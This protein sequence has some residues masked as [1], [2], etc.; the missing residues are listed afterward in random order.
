MRSGQAPGRQR[1]ASPWPWRWRPTT[2]LAPIIG[3]GRR[4]FR[5]RLPAGECGAPLL[6]VI[7]TPRVL[8]VRAAEE[9]DVRA[10]A[11]RVRRY[12]EGPRNSDG[13]FD[14][15][16][17]YY[18]ATANGLALGRVGG[19]GSAGLGLERFVSGRQLQ[20]LL[21][22]QHPTT[23]APLLGATGAA[24][25]A[26]GAPK[27]SRSTAADGPDD[28]LLSLAEAS[29]L[30]GVS[31]AYLRR[32]AEQNA[33]AGSEPAPPADGAAQDRLAAV[34]DPSSGAWRVRRAEVKRYIADREPPATVI[35]YDFV[36][37]AP[38]SVSLLWAFGDER[39]R[40]QIGA[41]M[42]ASVDV[43]LG[44]LEE[45][46]ARGLVG[47]RMHRGE[48]LV[49]A[50]YLHDVARTI[51]P[52]LHVHNLVANIVRIPRSDVAG[53]PVVDDNGV[54][55]IDSRAVDGT[56]ML[57]HSL[58][59]GYLAGA[60]LRHQL[61]RRLGVEWALPHNGVAEIASFPPDLLREF[62]TARARLLAEHASWQLDNPTAA[63]LEAARRQ[64]RD[65]KPVLADSEIAA[66]QRR[67]LA[68]LGWTPEA[69][70]SLIAGR[71]RR[72]TEVSDDEIAELFEQLSGPS[73]VTEKQTTFTPQHVR[74]AIA[75][76]AGER[77]DADR[78]DA[79][80]EQ[81][82]ADERVLLVGSANRRA[83]R[84]EPEAVYTTAGLLAVEDE[85]LHL[86]S[87]G[88][89]A[90]TGRWLCP[91]ADDLVD[92]GVQAAETQL[93]EE[94]GDPTAALAGEQAVMMRT[95]VNSG[96]LLRCAIGPAG[97]GKTE[98]LRAGVAAWTSAGYAVIGT[99][100][101]GMQAERLGTTLGIASDNLAALLA[102]WD[103]AEDGQH[104]ATLQPG[105]VIVVDE[106]TQVDSRQ[107]TRLLRWATLT[108]STVIAIG[109]PAQLG[110][111][112]AGG[113]FDAVV[114]AAERVPRLE[115]I[116]RQAGPELAGVRA[117]LTDLRS[118][119][120][121][122]VQR[123]LQRLAAEGRA[124]VFHERTDLYDQV[125]ADWYADR[126][127]RRAAVDSGRRPPKV[128]RMM[129]PTVAQCA[130]LN[131]G[132]RQLLVDD[133]TVTGQ[134]IST[135]RHDFAVGD[136]V[137]T[138]TQRGHTLLAE[139]ADKSDY[140][141]TGTVGIVVAVHADHDHPEQQHVVVDFEGKGRVVV[142]WE[143]LTFEFSDGRR[144]GLTHGY[145]LTADRAQG[146][147]MDA[148]RGVA[149]DATR[150]DALYVMLSRGQRHIAAYL[151]RG[152]DLRRGAN[153]EEFLPELTDR[154]TTLEAV[155]D[156]ARRH[157]AEELAV[158]FDPLAV[159]ADHLARRYLLHDLTRRRLDLPDPAIPMAALHRAESAAA[160]RAGA[161]G[162][163]NPHPAVVETL[164]ARPSG[165]QHRAQW[166]IA[167]RAVAIYTARHR[168][169]LTGGTAD[170]AHAPSQL[171]GPRP[172]AEGDHRAAA[173]GLIEA[174]ADRLPADVASRFWR[175]RERAA[176]HSAV[177]GVHALLAHGVAPSDI[178]RSLATTPPDG[179]TAAAVLA[180]R[181]S[182]L[183]ADRGI[184]PGGYQDPPP[185]PHDEWDAA[186]LAVRRAQTARHYARP[187]PEV[188]AERHAT[189]DP[190]LADILTAAL[191]AHVDQAVH[192]A[193]NGD[194]PAYLTGLLGPRHDDTTRWDH[195]CREIETWRHYRLG[196]LFGHSAESDSDDP[197][198]AALGPRPAD[199]AGAYTWDRLASGQDRLDLGLDHAI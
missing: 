103:S 112:G 73:G 164:G 165:G 30:A 198:L 183:C 3:P 40:R 13:V 71:P 196:L 125:V 155:I 65:P 120:P 23:G 124:S 178:A 95:L 12:V 81:F 82:L 78:I 70:T 135:G 108:G 31:P 154:R 139:G 17:A 45:H 147:T 107:A 11:K 7:V 192:R 33:T 51:E 136:E 174:W 72:P 100:A 130:T 66:R 61:A 19:A 94:T 21:A 74:R 184:D 2:V 56:A 24:G 129:A 6:A 101:R 131:R 157:R 64:T 5:V 117:A 63:T 97:T 118:G 28:E 59:A 138:L 57:D 176:R 27:G 168:P 43:A 187:L 149:S 29:H 8:G 76:W 146:S 197:L 67:Q 193:A 114:N 16:V 89:V 167:A 126:A 98:A 58:T 83:A 150:R 119:T 173:V 54:P 141:R 137:V 133:G 179:S 151:I 10:A 49:V 62:S 77:L 99:A 156:R 189:S 85:L 191:D 32:L 4:Q 48:G 20:H 106:A 92:E 185:A 96:D 158:D 166:D 93:R 68:A 1:S 121:A 52:H 88:A 160:A 105:T 199:R 190:H 186:I 115:H 55:I 37:A 163:A 140:V 195:D 152:Q 180:G 84:S 172:P 169:A 69:I 87:E 122:G 34:R 104:A 162:I 132:A 38:K 102:R 161:A 111:V 46:G 188:T 134:P 79:L 170:S 145:A 127:E 86:A 22:G 110:A 109:D 128:S 123:A 194:I 143:Y 36:C 113:W 144:G 91:V 148:A 171:L 60:E 47:G 35:A 14:G 80:A 116:H 181:V 153:D 39:M 42:L 25:R 182:K 41:A 50:S 18:A 142:P 53:N 177:A 175:A 9:A 159:T 44:Y 15:V 26:G 90:R 75:A